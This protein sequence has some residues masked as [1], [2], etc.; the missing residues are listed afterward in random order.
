MMDMVMP[1]LISTLRETTKKIDTLME[2]RKQRMEQDVVAE[3]EKKK[4]EAMGVLPGMP[5]PYANMPLALPAPS[6][7]AAPAALVSQGPVL[8]PAMVNGAQQMLMLTS[9]MPAQ[10]APGWQ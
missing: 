10:G 4:L 5:N 9:G 7:S 3:T 8:P 1:F 6:M 2:E